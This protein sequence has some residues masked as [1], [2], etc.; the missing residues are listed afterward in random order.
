MGEAFTTGQWL[1]PRRR[2]P[3]RPGLGLP[4]TRRPSRFCPAPGRTPPP[5]RPEGGRWGRRATSVRRGQTYRP[6]YH[7]PAPGIP[8]SLAGRRGALSGGSR[9]ASPLCN[10]ISS[11]AA[12]HAQGSRSPRTRMTE[13]G[14]GS[15][16]GRQLGSAHARHSQVTAAERSE[17]RPYASSR[18]KSLRL[19]ERPQTPTSDQLEASG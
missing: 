3:G 4:P 7:L 6:R 11:S 2:D 15:L 19:A 5:R 13:G 18:R 16:G 10:F 8:H 1:L 14:G 17:G 9:G 12:G